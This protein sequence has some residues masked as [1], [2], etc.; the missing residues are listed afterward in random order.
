MDIIS[1][2]HIFLLFAGIANFAGGI[3]SVVTWPIIRRKYRD[4]EQRYKG[5]KVSVI[6]PFK[7]KDFNNISYFL[8]QMYDDYEIIV[9]VDDEKEMEFIDKRAK[10]ALNKNI[11][12]CSGKISALLTGIEKAKGEIYVFADA[13]IKPHEEWLSYLVGNINGMVS[14]SYRWYFKNKLLS[15]WNCAAASLLFYQRFNF[16]WGGA[17]AIEKELFEKLKID[18][19]WRNE[20]VDDLT[21]TKAVKEAGYRINFVPQAIAEADEEINIVKWMNRQ[22]AWIRHYFPSLWKVAL[23]INVGMR[24]SNIT[25]FII[26]PFFPVTGLLLISPIIFDI[27]RGYEE[28]RSFK[29]LMKYSPSKFLPGHVYAL[30]RPAISFLITYNL[31]ASIFV[32]RIEWGGKIYEI[33][34]RHGA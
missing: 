33:G 9:V 8:Q 10:V 11:P 29:K 30:L 23:F 5:K 7:G 2:F 6:I 22:M 13:D 32:K 19:I 14:T 16:A 18:E 27:P 21:L 28:Y 20:I 4:S 34:G 31:L 15:C 25:G 3:L 1:A 12:T 17:T 26:L 24:I